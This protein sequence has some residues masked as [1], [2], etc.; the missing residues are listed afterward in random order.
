MNNPKM[1]A[2]IICLQSQQNTV[3]FY[4]TGCPVTLKFLQDQVLQ[5]QIFFVY[6]V[7]SIKTNKSYNFYYIPPEIHVKWC[8]GKAIKFWRL[9]T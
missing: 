2:C 9:G 8:W 6:L 4:R 5:D 3:E 1:S 7:K